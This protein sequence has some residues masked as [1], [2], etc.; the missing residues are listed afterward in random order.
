[1][2]SRII[3]VSREFGS[4]GRAIGQQVAE[5][6]GIPVYDRELIVQTAAA[7]GLD[8]AYIQEYGEY[9]TSTSRFLYNW[10]IHGGFPD[11]YPAIPDYLYV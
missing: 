1:M 7:S 8:P 6:L 11:S 4:G 9:A 2:A 3:T 5:R 10:E